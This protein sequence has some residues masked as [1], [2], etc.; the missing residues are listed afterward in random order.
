MKTST[1]LIFVVAL[2]AFWWIVKR[3]REVAENFNRA[4]MERLRT[5]SGD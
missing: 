5:G 1:L 3:T 2:L 4:Q